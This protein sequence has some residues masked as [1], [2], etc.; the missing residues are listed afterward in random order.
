M[1]RGAKNISDQWRPAASWVSQHGWVL[2]VAL[3]GGGLVHQQYK[4]SKAELGVQAAPAAAKPGP[5][6]FQ[7]IY[8]SLA[9]GPNDKKR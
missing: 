3:I 1:S 8:Q 7:L 2:G 4:T 5:G 9:G 6:P